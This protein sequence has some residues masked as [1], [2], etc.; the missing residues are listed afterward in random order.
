M[1]TMTRKAM[2]KAATATRPLPVEVQ[3]E[4]KLDE[5]RG[6]DAYVCDVCDQWTRNLPL[7]R[8]EVCPKKERRKT[9]RRS[10][11]GDEEPDR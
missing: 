2:K 10:T 3:H 8:D 4:W 5:S 9:V 7:Y 11:D 6:D 1:K